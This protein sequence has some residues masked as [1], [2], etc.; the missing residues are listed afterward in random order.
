VVKDA[1]AKWARFI[2]VARHFHGSSSS[3]EQETRD[4][5]KKLLG[6]HAFEWKQCGPAALSLHKPSEVPAELSDETV[7]AI[8]S[9]YAFQLKRRSNGGQWFLTDLNLGPPEG[10]DVQVGKVPIRETWKANCPGLF[11]AQEW[12]PDMFSSSAL[13]VTG[14]SVPDAERPNLIRVEFDHHVLDQ[15]KRKHLR[16]GWLLLDKHRYWFLSAYEVRMRYE[17]DTL[18]AVQSKEYTYADHKH[19]YPIPERVVRRHTVIDTTSGATVFER[20]ETTEYKIHEQKNVPEREFSL[21]AFNLPEPPG[22][23]WRG[24]KL[25]L[26][27][28]LAGA[29]ALAL[30][31]FFWQRGR[32]RT[33]P[34]A[35]IPGA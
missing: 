33:S 13:T 16:S 15:R 19:N 35:A 30:A 5:R 34:P 31:A 12:L 29:G 25:Y 2:A 9:K 1:P 4:G 26:W 10:D 18:E 27:V 32:A 14:A 20:E 6:R 8:N 22:V 23:S 17:G 3:E 24:S 11:L 7:L 28:S 21:T